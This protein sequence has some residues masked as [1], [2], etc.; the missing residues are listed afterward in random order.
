MFES[1]IKACGMYRDTY[2]ITLSFSVFALL[3][4]S[5]MMFLSSYLAV[6]AGMI[7]FSSIRL[8]MTLGEAVFFAAVSLASTALFAVAIA[9]IVSITKLKETLDQSGFSKILN[10]FPNYTMRIF[11]F[12]ILLTIITVLISAVA[13]LLSL[14]SAITQ[15]LLFATWVFFIFVPQV[16]ILEDYP[17]ITSLKDSANFV[18]KNPLILFEYLLI[19]TVLLVLV[20]VTETVLGQFLVFEQNMVGVVLVSLIVL[21]LTQMYASELYLKRYPLAGI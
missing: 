16:I 7:R 11:L 14:P 9:S 15:I 18:S 12:L 1:F 2:K 8:D 6:G 10:V 3:S 5:M 13:G 19:G 4:L 21:P 17:L 20:A